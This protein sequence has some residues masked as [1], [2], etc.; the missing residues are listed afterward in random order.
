MWVFNSRLLERIR[1]NLFFIIYEMKFTFKYIITGCLFF[2][3][4]IAKSQTIIPESIVGIWV[5]QESVRSE[6]NAYVSNAKTMGFTKKVSFTSQNIAITYKNDIEIR[7]SDY[8]IEK[9]NGLLDGL[10][11]YVV[12][13][14]GQSYI[15]KKLDNQNLILESNGQYRVSLVFKKSKK[16]LK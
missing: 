10:E 11:Y 14:D 4:F 2:S 7:V 8:K 5:L 16:R 12:K 13:F 3:V 1:F 6:K 15:L 9:G